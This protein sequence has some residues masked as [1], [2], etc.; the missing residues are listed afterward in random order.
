MGRRQREEE[1]FGRVF[2]HVRG[3]LGI[4][5][6][7][8]AIRLGVSERT[9]TRWTNDEDPPATRAR[10]LMHELRAM[11]TPAPLL[12]RAAATLGLPPEEGKPLVVVDTAR[13]KDALDVAV[14]EEAEAHELRPAVLRGAVLAV[15]KRAAD[16]S[17][18]ARTAHALL[19][20]RKTR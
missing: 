14:F 9:M 5:S 7:T 6:Q 15:L 8:L 3:A 12:A 19:A 1:T 2:L 10:E 20:S 11:G 13:A 18:D 17:L 4:T 16:L